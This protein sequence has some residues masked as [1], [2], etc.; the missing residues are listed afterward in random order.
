[1]M[2]RFYRWLLWIKKP[3]NSLWVTPALG[4]LLAIIFALFASGITRYLPPNL[5]PEIKQDTLDGLLSV[6]ASSMLAVSTF[7]L[8]IMVSAF[9]SAA[10]SATPRATELVMADDN[11]RLAIASF[12]SAFIYAIIAKVALGMGYYGPNGRFIL[13]IS[14]MLVLVY[15]IVI[16]IR[17]VHTLS[18]LGRMGNTLAKIYQT[19]R[20]ILKNYRQHPQ[21]NTNPSQPSAQSLQEA[22]AIQSQYSGYLTNIHL[23]ALQSWA[24]VH[25]QRLHIN[26]RAGD[27]LTPG[28]TLLYLLPAEEAEQSSEHFIL[29]DTDR[30]TLYD[31]FALD[32]ERSYSQDPRFGF[33]VLSE[34]AQRALSPA[35]NDPGTAFSVLTLITKLILDHYETPDYQT[36]PEYPLIS[37]KPLDE[38]DFITQSIRPI[39]RDGAGN[40]EVALRLQK[41]LAS[42]AQS[43]PE[44]AIR[45]AA[46]LET[47][48]AYRRAQENLD[49]S[50][51][52]EALASQYEHYFGKFPAQFAG[53]MSQRPYSSIER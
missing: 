41:T 52:Q 5:L 29:G 21:M 10:G 11:T 28:K 32:T 46:Y 24:E 19:S 22:V 16:L 7:S 23:S 34:V 14:T 25:H 4:A 30:S 44:R 47:N 48:K 53:E 18:Q 15:L 3:G 2:S 13:F 50:D 45:N 1:M 40:I 17:W 49:F 37:I 27:Y 26:C 9:S 20:S 42:I 35:V 39:A 38:G 33:I 6:I 43:A 31:C 36:E 12:I 8:S 51:D